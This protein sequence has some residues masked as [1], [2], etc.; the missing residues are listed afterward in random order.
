ML[1]SEASVVVIGD[2]EH[3]AR[4]ISKGNIIVLGALKGTA[5]AGMAGN[6]EAVVVAL[7]MAPTQI[8]ICDATSR[9]NERNRRLGRGPMIAAAVQD[10]VQIQPI[11][12]TFLNNMLNLP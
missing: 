9:F 5:A 10:E 4:I 7:E 2:V 3:G 8:R 12:K 6:Q 1:E 11:K